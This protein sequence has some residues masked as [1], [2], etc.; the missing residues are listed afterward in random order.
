MTFYKRNNVFSKI[1]RYLVNIAFNNFISIDEHSVIGR[2]T[3]IGKNSSITKSTI[4]NYCSIGTGVMIGLGEHSISNLS[5]SS[6]FYKDD[7]YSVLTK[8]PVKIGSDV[9]IGANAI[10]LR[11]VVIETGAVVGAGAVVTKDVPPYAVVVGVPAKIIKYRFPQH[12]INRLLISEWWEKDKK[13]AE[14]ILK[15]L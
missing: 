6:E 1:V 10:V 8:R 4:G 9:W 3:F 13:D 11:G 14:K 5:T 15:D 12:K 2:Y 7:V